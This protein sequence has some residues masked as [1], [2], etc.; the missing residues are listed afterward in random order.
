MCAANSHGPKQKWPTALGHGPKIANISKPISAGLGWRSNGAAPSWLK[1]RPTGS[2][3]QWPQRSA[4]SARN[5]LTQQLTALQSENN[6]LRQAAD[7][8][9]E[10]LR[11][12]AAMLSMR[13][14]E[15]MKRNEALAMADGRTGAPKAAMRSAQE[16][17]DD[18]RQKLPARPETVEGTSDDAAQP[19]A[20]QLSAAIDL[21]PRTRLSPVGPRQPT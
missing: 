19:A 6:T 18:G 11:A 10:Q 13:E 4:S 5:T 15:L 20:T 9:R 3:V 2:E 14:R 12:T 21:V 7:D 1:C 16:V 17:E 8:A